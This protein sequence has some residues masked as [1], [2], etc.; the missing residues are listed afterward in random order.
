[1]KKV[2]IT[3]VSLCI[4]SAFSLSGCNFFNWLVGDWLMTPQRKITDEAMQRLCAAVEQNDVAAV[5]AAFSY[6]DIC[7]VEGFDGQ[8][9]KL[10]GYVAGE[11]ISF[12]RKASGSDSAAMGYYPEEREFGGVRYN[13]NTSTDEYKVVFGYRSYYSEKENTVNKQKIGFIYFDII[14]LKNDRETG[15]RFYTGCP[16]AYN[17]INF[18]YKTS[19]I[20]SPEE[21]VY[22]AAFCDA[23]EDFEPIIFNGACELENFYIE[24]R[25]KYSLE[26]RVDG[27]GFKDIAARYDDGF[28]A[29]YSLYAVGFYNKGGGFDYVPQFLY[30]GDF[31]L[32]NITAFTQERRSDDSSEQYAVD[33]VILFFEL[34]EK[35]AEGTSA[36]VQKDVFYL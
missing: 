13:I 16:F 15:D 31:V 25:E 6:D 9:E 33:G 11:N 10:C 34:P 23:L 29:E 19:Y 26:S 17:G 4:I 12:V 32:A 2:F 5:K 27:K 1:M 14:N 21:Y 18:D 3:A 7:G 30:V 24:N 22:T 36:L 28:F 20:F 35:V 8:A